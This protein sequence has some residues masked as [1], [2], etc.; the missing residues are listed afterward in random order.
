MNKKGF[1]IP[2]YFFVILAIVLACA[3]FLFAVQLPF[4]NKKL[5]EYTQKHNAAQA[6]INQWKDYMSRAKEVQASI[7]DMKAQ[8]AEKSNQLS[9]DPDK[10]I[11]D[12]KDM[13]ANMGYDPGTVSVAHGQ[14][15]SQGRV[16]ETGEALLE[17]AITFNFSATKTD[18][19][20]TFKYFES[21][22]KG[23]YYITAITISPIGGAAGVDESRTSSEMYS[24][25]M[26]LTL[27]YF[28]VPVV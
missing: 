3:I 7:D 5:P 27:Y 11:D 10:T 25:Q 17:T 12:I 6:Q 19:L 20:D 9:V 24:V 18:M 14:A 28:E 13:L 4:A 16:A 2:K 23:S 21:E 22:S 1:T 15:D 26:S 8:Y